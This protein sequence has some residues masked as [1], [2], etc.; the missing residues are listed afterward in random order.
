[1]KALGLVLLLTCTASAGF[2]QTDQKSKDCFKTAMTQSAM[3]V[4]ANE[5]AQRAGGQLDNTYQQLL[6]LAKKDPMAIAKIKKAEAIWISYR[7][8]Y[9][10]AMYP[11]T[12]KQGYGTAFPM[13][14]D[15]LEA[16]LT[17]QQTKA[18][19]E[20]IRTYTDAE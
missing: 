12:D 19:Q 6:T 15:L 5:E 17:R 4:C 8:A 18:L 11:A 13:E 1:M 2:G 3:D 9:I 14:V 10:D 16:D 20:I 7:Q